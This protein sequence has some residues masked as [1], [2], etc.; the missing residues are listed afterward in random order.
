MKVVCLLLLFTS[1]TNV[2]HA[3]AT[4]PT[5]TSSSQEVETS[6]WMDAI[7]HRHQQLI[8]LN[9]PGIDSSLRAQLLDM[10]DAD[11][12]IRTEVVQAAKVAGKQPDVTQLHATDVKLTSELKEIVARAGWPTIHLVGFD[13]SHAAMLILT[14]SEDRA[15]QLQMLPSLEKLASASKIDNSQLA[16]LIDKELVASGKLQMYGTQ[17]KFTPGHIA[18]YAVEQ[19]ATLDA[20]RTDSMLPPIEVYKQ[21]LYAAYNIPVS[22]ETIPPN[23]S[24]ASSDVSPK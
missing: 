4:A 1:I 8:D 5:P 2:G 24:N 13:A 18:M 20:R 14:H 7:G 12:K 11:Q 21:M 10:G 19:P 17:F 16:L 6:A 23:S 15:W 3:Q 22:N 9:G